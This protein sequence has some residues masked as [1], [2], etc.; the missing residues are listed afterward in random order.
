MKIRKKIRYLINFLQ[1]RK[2]L[3]K[4]RLVVEDYDYILIGHEASK[5]G[6]PLLLLKIA[7]EISKRGYKIALVLMDLGSLT[8]QY[9]QVV[10]VYLGTGL[11]SD[12]N[13]CRRGGGKTRILINTVVAGALAPAFGRIRE[14]VVSLVHEM[15]TVIE[16][17]EAEP[18]TVAICANS[19]FVVF[20]STEVKT[21]LSKYIK[22]EYKYKIM[23]QGIYNNRMHSMSKSA[24]AEFISNKYFS[25]CR[26]DVVLNVGSGNERKGFDIFLKLSVENPDLNFIWVGPF[27]KK[28][29][30]QIIGKAKTRDLKNI[31]LP[32]YIDCE[33]ELAK[34][35][36]GAKVF[37]L[38]S[39]EEP[40][41]SV[42]LEA[43]SAGTP[44]VGFEGVGGF[45]DV[46]EPGV[47]GN[48]VQIENTWEL[49]QAIKEICISDKYDQMAND[50]VIHSKQYDFENYVSKILGLYEL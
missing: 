19:K 38:T 17:W 31:R 25:Q 14:N 27:D 45:N 5:T 2:Y 24:C 10:D 40:L 11:P 29:Y 36:R 12:I 44:V 21:G 13:L 18:Y 47:T 22:N 34:L 26:K 23:P 33:D 3:S 20:P 28:I 15:P 4:S 30:R 42:V 1:F 50:C 6:A 9:S 41:G 32:G 7:N 16:K 49:A 37:C 8:P 46:I 39:R 48:F 43:L 35:Y